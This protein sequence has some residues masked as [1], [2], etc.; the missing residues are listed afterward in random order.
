MEFITYL[1]ATLWLFNVSANDFLFQSLQRLN[2]SACQE[3]I[4]CCQLPQVSLNRFSRCCSCDQ[5]PVR[6]RWG[7]TCHVSMLTYFCV[8]TQWEEYLPLLEKLEVLYYIVWCPSPRIWL[9]EAKATNM[10]MSWGEDLCLIPVMANVSGS[11]RY[12]R[13]RTKMLEDLVS[14]LPLTSL[15]ILS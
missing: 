7:S 11:L 12:S 10:F 14:A 15:G 3:V 6:G 8:D 2:D 5:I 1:S 9:M 4:L 13:K